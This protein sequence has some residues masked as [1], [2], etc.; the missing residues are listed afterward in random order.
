M[1]SP[2]A[3]GTAAAA[4]STAS[5]SSLVPSLRTLYRHRHLIVTLA[6]RDLKARYRGSL[7]GFFWS[8]ANPLLLLGVYTL[9]FTR[10]FPRPD[11]DPYPLFLFT[12]ILP[13]SFFAGAVT[14]SATSILNNG[15]L[16]K[17][18]LFPAEALPIVVVVSHLVHFV[19]ALPVLLLAVVVAFLMDKIALS[20]WIVAAPAVIL[21]QA[22]FVCG[23]ALIVSAVTVLFRDLRDLIATS[24]QLLF[25]L[26]PILYRAD[27]IPSKALRALLRVNPMTAFVSAY[28]SI[29]V[30][31]VRPALL[32]VVLMLVYTLFAVVAGLII[33]DRLRDPVAEAI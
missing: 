13:W 21:V 15:S 7:L 19:L 32:D 24:L 10:F 5:G 8:L 18:V 11:I 2:P 3:T 31:G 20:T 30:F 27:A 33:F 16:L 1:S 9:V 4:V 23:V 12:G 6:S 17:K 25:F 22:I 26:T 14:E 28:Q 29:F